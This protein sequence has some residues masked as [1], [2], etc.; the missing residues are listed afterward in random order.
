MSGFFAVK[1]SALPELSSLAPLGYKIALEIMVRGRLRA[2]EVP[3]HF[4]GRHAGRSKTGWAQRWQF[5][6]HI[7]RLYAF[8]HGGKLKAVSHG[9]WAGRALYADL[10]LYLGLLLLECE[11]RVARVWVKT[12]ESQKIVPL[13]LDICMMIQGSSL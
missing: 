3:I 4:A 7:G 11:H 6:R 10:A 8:K 2:Y 1:R 5:L 9:L 12:P 13:F